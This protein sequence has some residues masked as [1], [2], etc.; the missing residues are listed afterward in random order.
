VS[1]YIPAA[2]DVQTWLAER[3]GIIA[4]LELAP[5]TPEHLAAGV[6]A[7][8]QLATIFTEWATTYPSEHAAQA[9]QRLADARTP[10]DKLAALEHIARVRDAVEA[11]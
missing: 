9:A 11:T 1:R 3:A 4:A 2:L 7:L 6:E 5:G 10:A 8:D